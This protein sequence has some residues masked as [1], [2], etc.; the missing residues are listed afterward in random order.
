MKDWRKT[1]SSLVTDYLTSISVR[2]KRAKRIAKARKLEWKLSL[3]DFEN[4][5]NKPCF[6]CNNKLGVIVSMSTGLDRLDN[7]KG[8]ITGNIVSCCNTCN[9][10]R[11]NIL[12]VHEMQEVVKLLCKLRNI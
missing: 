6:Y 12:S 10:I 8:Y 3:E 9:T 11:S 2:Y 4:L 1:N 7:S 5:A